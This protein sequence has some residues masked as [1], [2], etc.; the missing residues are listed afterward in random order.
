MRL[1]NPEQDQS[2]SFDFLASIGKSRLSASVL[3]SL[4]QRVIG[5]SRFVLS[6]AGSMRCCSWGFHPY[7]GQYAWDRLAV[8]GKQMQPNDGSESRY[9][10]S[11]GLMIEEGESCRI[12]EYA[13]RR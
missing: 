3:I 11:H 5:S 4:A 8:Q 9:S 6:I 2:G 1:Q 13:R 10:D 7:G 12:G